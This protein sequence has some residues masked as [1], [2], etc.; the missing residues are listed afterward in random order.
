M[1]IKDFEVICINLE[2]RQDRWEESIKEF[3]KA[4]L[5]MVYRYEVIPNLNPVVGCAES[6]FEVLEYCLKKDKHAM[7]FE[8][9][10]KFINDYKNIYEYLNELDNRDWDM[11]YMGGNITYP[12]YR[13]SD[14]IAR[15]FRIQST[16]AYCVNKKLIPTILSRKY[17]LGKPMDL[18]YSEDIVPN[19]MCYITVPMLA[20]QRPSYSDIEQKRV[21]YNWMEER[22]NNNLVERSD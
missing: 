4:H 16:H 11:L 13:I 3:H 15:V 18:I 8:D 2:N 20:I 12:F 5:N 14:K 1:D 10:V 7:I 19:N 22:Y 9:D 6:H 21:D 17:L